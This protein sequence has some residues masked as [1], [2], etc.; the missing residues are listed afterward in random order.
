MPKVRVTW[1][2]AFGAVRNTELVSKFVA[3]DLLVCNDILYLLSKLSWCR[4]VALRNPIT[5]ISSGFQAKVLDAQRELDKLA[6]DTSLR[7]YLK[8]YVPVLNRAKGM[9]ALKTT[10]SDV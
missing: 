3:V 6:S 10:T 1:L 4:Y 7:P 2:A 5:N 9:C 8:A